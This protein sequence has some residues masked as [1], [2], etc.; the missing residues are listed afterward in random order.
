MKKIIIVPLLI[1]LFLNCS[2]VEADVEYNILT[3]EEKK[4]IIEKGTELPFSGIFNDNKE[5][6]LY[7][8]KRCNEPLFWSEY[9]F[10][11]SC[12]WP[13]FD[14]EI[15]DSIEYL[16]DPDGTRTEIVCSNCGAHLGHVFKGEGFTSKNLRH[17]V[18]SI[19]MNFIPNKDIEKAVFAGGCFWGVQYYFEKLDGVITTRVGYTGGTTINPTYRDVSSGTTGH[20]EAIEIAYNPDVVT[21]EDLARLFFE[22]HDFTQVDGQGPD[23]G[24]QYLSVI[25]YNSEKQKT[26][27][28][29]LMSILRIKKYEV[30]TELKE[31]VTF[32]EAEDYHQLYY[33][34]KGTLPYC[35]FYKKIF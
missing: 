22:I 34:K 31:A 13:S 19:S 33:Q 10:D 32:W 17:C 20:V 35:H 15:N 14:D 5:R 27:S 7:I 4:V 24:E 3:E 2:K 6:G 23:I 9:K 30:A 16:E 8:C 12:G 28:E 18:N 29:E 1:L 11:S 21:F 26:I 25:F